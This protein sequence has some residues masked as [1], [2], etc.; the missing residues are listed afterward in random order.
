MV[1]GLGETLGKFF[2]LKI[3]D[4]EFGRRFGQYS[5]EFGQNFRQT[6]WSHCYSGFQKSPRAL[7][8]IR[9]GLHRALGL[10][11]MRLA[12]SPGSR[13]RT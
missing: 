8:T 7:K 1:F 10:C 9:P 12:L 5:T 11:S 6:I 13:A 4:F 2:L 3:S